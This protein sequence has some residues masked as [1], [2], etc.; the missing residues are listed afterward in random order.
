MI[1]T[2]KVAIM[3]NPRIVSIF[4]YLTFA[5]ELPQKLAVEVTLGGA[6]FR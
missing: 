6:T 5:L 2:K 1:N 3:T 4:G